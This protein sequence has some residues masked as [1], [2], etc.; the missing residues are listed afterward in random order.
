MLGNTDS[1]LP[2]L[3]CAL[4]KPINLLFLASPEIEICIFLN[5]GFGVLFKFSLEVKDIGLDGIYDGFDLYPVVVLDLCIGWRLRKGK[6]R[7]A[8]T[9]IPRSAGFLLVGKQ[10]QRNFY[11]RELRGTQ[12]H[13]RSVGK[14]LYPV[15]LRAH[16]RI[17]THDID[18]LKAFQEEPNAFHVGS[19]TADRRSNLKER[20]L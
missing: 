15:D 11:L 17:F 13:H 14:Y 1:G 8:M 19:L 16:F 9:M 7:R 10:A 20:S 5:L 6:K 12:E 3:R 4:I 2:S 18:K